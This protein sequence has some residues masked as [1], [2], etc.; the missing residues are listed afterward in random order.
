MGECNCI[1]IQRVS[2]IITLILT[3]GRSRQEQ[4]CY[5]PFFRNIIFIHQRAVYLLIFSNYL[6]Q[7][8]IVTVK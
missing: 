3:S 2:E 4:N 6:T 7:Y 1:L 8:V 5:V